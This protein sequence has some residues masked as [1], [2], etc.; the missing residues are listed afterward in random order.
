MNFLNNEG[1][2][3]GLVCMQSLCQHITENYQKIEQMIH[4]ASQNNVQILVF[5]ELSLSGYCLI[6]AKEN[7]LSVS[8]P[9]IKDIRQ[10]AQEHHMTVLAGIAEKAENDLFITQLICHSDGRLDGYRKTHPGQREQQIFSL[11]NQLPVFSDCT[12]FGVEL[13]YD[14]HFPEVST[15]LALSGAQILFI[16][17]AIPAMAGNR[18]EIWNKFMPARAYDNRVFVACCNLTGTNGC[19]TV[20]DGGMCIYDPDGMMIAEDFSGKESLLIVDLP[21]QQVMQYRTPTSY[22]YKR[23]YL[24]HRRPELYK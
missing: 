24:A 3:V 9:I 18:K 17:H 23:Y 14:A 20:F 11:G 4:K 13:C 21:I 15:A 16:P 1:C 12:N 8:D 7:V 2:R 5:P 19:G 6:H 10:C 22:F